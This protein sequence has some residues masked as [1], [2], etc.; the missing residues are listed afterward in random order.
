ME[1][2]E[3]HFQ[4][5]HHQPQQQRKKN[6]LQKR[7]SAQSSTSTLQFS[8]RFGSDTSGNV[9]SDNNGEV[10][11]KTGV[12]LQFLSAMR[13]VNWGSDDADGDDNAST[14]DDEDVTTG[15]RRFLPRFNAQWNTNNNGV[16][17][18]EDAEA[19]LQWMPRF[20]GV[21]GNVNNNCGAHANANFNAGGGGAVLYSSTGVEGR[22]PSAR[23]GEGECS[24]MVAAQN[25]MANYIPVF[26]PK[27]KSNRGEE[28]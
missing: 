28:I 3:A 7:R 16:Y 25:L 6:H 8:P 20:T 10:G 13:D 1:S 5:Q 15:S 9:L 22:S 27:V 18:H 17:P 23:P 12:P 26:N 14:T 19:P 24:V 21:D 2:Y 4:R 11:R